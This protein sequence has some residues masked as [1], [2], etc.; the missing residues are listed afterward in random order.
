MASV[1][2]LALSWADGGRPFRLKRRPE[3]RVRVL[4]AEM[5]L[6]RFEEVFHFIAERLAVGEKTIVA[7]HNLHSLYLMRRSASMR[8]F[9]DMADLIEVDSMPLIFWARLMG[10]RSRTF[11][12]C[13][14]LDWREEFW[15]LAIE[16]GWR[17]FFIGGKPG[18][19]EAAQARLL[20][21]WP[22][23][24]LSVHT[25]YFDHRPGSIDNERLL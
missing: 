8:R 9:F 10:R 21:Q 3:E 12:R 19:A 13:T 1:S 4:G 15:A 20:K 24:T 14:Y 17:V 23:A 11:H 18:V 7:N 5:D 25:G 6:V 2:P 16:R 22:M